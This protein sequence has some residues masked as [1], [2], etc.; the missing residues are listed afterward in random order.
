ML[1]DK[2]IKPPF[3]QKGVEMR[4]GLDI[5]SYAADQS[6]DRVILILGGTVCLPVIECANITGLQVV[7]AQFPKQ[8]NARELKWHSDF[9]RLRMVTTV[10]DRGRS[11][12]TD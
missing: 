10:I 11:A 2:N 12:T 6:M 9:Q 5:A 3:E 7:L 4:L 8:L 1:S